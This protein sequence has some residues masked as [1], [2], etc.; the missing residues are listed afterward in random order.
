MNAIVLL[1]KRQSNP[2][3]TTP[4]P[5]NE[6]LTTL[7]AAGMRVPDHGGLKPWHFHV[8]SGQGLQRLSD[9]YLAAVSDELRNS[10]L[11]EQTISD[12]KTK[13]AK[14]P[15]RAPMI[16]V[17]STKYVEHGKVPK[18]EQLIEAGCC[19]H[20]MQMAAFALGYGAMWRT[21]DL[22]YNDIVKAGLGLEQGNDIAGFLYIGTP[23]KEGNEKPTK[24]YV[25]NV[26]YWR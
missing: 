5:N 1:L 17:V 11:E 23:I 8:I 7:I 9:I 4:V 26:T 6:D 12:K 24:P 15:F 16:I 19:A 13:T 10:D 21:G 14:M 18:Q 3:L 22:A 2:A 25:N 20:A